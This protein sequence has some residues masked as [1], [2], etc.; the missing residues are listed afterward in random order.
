MEAEMNID[1]YFRCYATVNLDLIHKNVE[2]M[3]E[4]LN[5]ETKILAVIKTDGYGHGAVPVAKALED[6]CYGYAIAT[7]YEGH[8]L[9]RHNINKPIF[10]LGYVPETEID[11]AINEDMIP[12][13]FS[14]EMAEIISK[15]AVN[16]GK[17]VKINIAVDTGMS[18][19]G[20]IPSESAISEVVNISKLP[21]IEIESI[22][23]HFAK[24]DYKDK[25]FTE[26]QLNEFNNFING[27]ERAGV[28]IPIHQCANSAAMMEMPDTNMNISRAGISMYG[29]YPSEEMDKENMKLY[30]A[31]SVYSHVVHVKEIEAG[32]GISYGQTFVADKPMK[33]ATIPMGYGDGYP[34]SLSNTGY[35]LINGKR[36]NIVGRVC[37]DQFMV[38]VTGMDVKTGDLVVLA[39]KSGDEE[40]FIDELAVTAGSFNYE[41]ICDIGKRVP[42]VYIKDQKIVGTKDY[43]ADDYEIDL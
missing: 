20:Y 19:I 2:V 39:G 1:K 34:R 28:T 14:M 43:F 23:T 31:M 22:F 25:S 41:F 11:I 8:N 32:R 27:L 18:R 9:R 35:V 10:I 13:V 7:A 26:K 3:K 33:I 37:M 29:L 4:R 15:H 24:A 6:I 30:P 42:R 16:A 5:P 38:D 12:P 21:N 17:T 36:A 40:I